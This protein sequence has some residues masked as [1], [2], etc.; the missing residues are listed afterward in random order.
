MELI[1]TKVTIGKQED[2][3]SMG[4]MIRHNKSTRIVA[5]SEKICLARSISEVLSS[6]SW[7]GE[8]CFLIGGG[9]SLKNFNFDCLRG[10]LTIGINKA[11]TRFSPT[12]NYGMDMGFYDKVMYDAPTDP[13]RVKLHQ[14]WLGYKGIKAFLR[15]RNFKL[16][17][18]VYVVEDLGKEKVLSFDLKRGIFG[19]NNSGFGAL[20]LAIALGATKIGLLGY[21]MKVDKRNKKTH[22]HSGYREQKFDSMQNKLDKFQIYFNVFAST[23][24]K[25]G[26]TVVNLSPDS[27]LDC[28]EKDS[29]GNF[30][31]KY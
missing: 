10:E 2:T 16:D 25:E 21:D 29:L 8:R 6:S 22:W 9:P 14:Q 5:A 19:G 13:E 1:V 11:F 7:K 27:N 23:I 17:S 26:I 12:I 4:V 28:F 3:D 18:S 20:M 30:L 15:R 24:A 31:K